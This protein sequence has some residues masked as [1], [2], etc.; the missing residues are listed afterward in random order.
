ME[1][2]SA[3]ADSPARRACFTPIELYTKPDGQYDKLLT[4]DGPLLTTLAKFFWV[5]SVEQSPM[6]KYPC[7]QNFRITVWNRPMQ[8]SMPDKLEF[9]GTDTD[10]D[11]DTDIRDAPIV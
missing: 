10:T 7:I 8:S 3:D 2:V 4:D 5:Q 9:R 11:T 1:K 6:G